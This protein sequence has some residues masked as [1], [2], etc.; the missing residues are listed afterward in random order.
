MFL[1][2]SLVIFV[3]D[4]IVERK[5]ELGFFGFEEDEE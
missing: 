3:Y 1:V 2:E 4:A 5:N